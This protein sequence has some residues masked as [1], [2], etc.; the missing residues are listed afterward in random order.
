MFN[1]MVKHDDQR[2]LI[3]WFIS[4]TTKGGGV[5]FVGELWLMN[6]GYT[7]TY[8]V[9]TYQFAMVSMANI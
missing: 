9:G 3:G 8:I 2:R 4:S 7:Y 6:G 1:M 5:M